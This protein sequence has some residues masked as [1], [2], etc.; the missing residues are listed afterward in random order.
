MHTFLI[1]IVLYKKD[2]QES[3]SLQSILQSEHDFFQY[4]LVIWDNSPVK[5]L[6]KQDLEVIKE[7]ICVDYIH[8]SRNESLSI[9]YNLS[10]IHI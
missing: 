10:L 5:M 4:K 9:V 2:I 6:D 8:N 3:E 1:L 7:K